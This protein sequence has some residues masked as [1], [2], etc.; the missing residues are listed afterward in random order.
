M[1]SLRTLLRLSGED[2]RLF[3]HALLAVVAVRLT[4]RL[5]D[6]AALR[7]WAA[8]FGRGARPVNRIAWAVRAAGRRVP[9]TNC[10]VSSLALQRMLSRHGHAS[11]LHIGVAKRDGVLAAHA[12]VVCDD[13]VFDGEGGDDAYTRLIAWRAA[14]TT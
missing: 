2:R 14:E 10:L 11:E 3:V 13:Q 1:S 9:G 5:V 12:W 8:R 6:I 7:R 4:L